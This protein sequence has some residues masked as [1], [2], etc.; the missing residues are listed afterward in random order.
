MAGPTGVPERDLICPTECADLEEFASILERGPRPDFDAD[1]D[2][3][4]LEKKC[5]KSATEVLECPKLC[6]ELVN[7]DDSLFNHCDLENLVKWCQVKTLIFRHEE[8]RSA[9]ILLFSKTN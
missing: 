3:S 2:V 5:H 1:C 7:M 4:V 9:K 8:T 6:S